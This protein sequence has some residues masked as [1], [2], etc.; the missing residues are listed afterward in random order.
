[1]NPNFIAPYHGVHYHLSKF[2]NGNL[3]TN[4]KE[5]FNRHHFFL[6]DMIECTFRILKVRFPILTTAPPYPIK[7]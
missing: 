3:P 4:L 2:Q 6:R 1:M 5:L 7:I